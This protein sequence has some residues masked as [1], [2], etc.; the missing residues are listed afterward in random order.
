MRFE[1]GFLTFTIIIFF[2]ILILYN[3]AMA[4]IN[5][6]GSN[7]E[8]NRC[9]PGYMPLARF[10]GHNPKDNFNYCVKKE[11]QK[12]MSTY[13]EPVNQALIEAEKNSGGNNDNIQDIRIFLNQQCKKFNLIQILKVKIYG[14]L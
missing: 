5:D 14:V 10:F 12:H 4:K 13:L 7:W 11:Q 9:K 6:V 8:K 3:L 2:G 1:D